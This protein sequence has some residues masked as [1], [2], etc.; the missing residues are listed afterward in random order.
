M[1]LFVLVT[2]LAHVV[3]AAGVGAHA[4]VTGRNVWRWVPVVL[5]TGVV[6]LGWY[7]T[8]TTRGIEPGGPASGVDPHAGSGNLETAGDEVGGAGGVKGAEDAVD[9]GLPEQV[10]D[11]DRSRTK[12]LAD[13][14]SLHIDLPD[15]T[16]LTSE[17]Q[18]AVSAV[19]EYLEENPEATTDDIVSDVFPRNDNGYHDHRVWWTEI[20]HP[21]LEGL[22]EVEPPADAEEATLS[23]H[24]SALEDDLAEETVAVTDGENR[25][26]FEFQKDTP[27]PI[28]AKELNEYGP[29]WMRLARDA[30]QDQYDRADTETS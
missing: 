15:C 3:L 27:V 20:I 21:A 24:V 18:R 9:G 14:N 25:A 4:E 12:R 29:G 19:I 6:G 7:V 30:I 11:W 2:L 26:V 16:T 8:R 1:E 23:F 28:R 10:P 13:P 5:V 22:P 17:D